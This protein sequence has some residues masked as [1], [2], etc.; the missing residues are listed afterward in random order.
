MDWYEV[1]GASGIKTLNK[2]APNIDP[3]KCA[4]IITVSRDGVKRPIIL[5]VSLKGSNGKLSFIKGK[6]LPKT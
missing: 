4:G 3:K 1:E 2:T 5:S 6:Y